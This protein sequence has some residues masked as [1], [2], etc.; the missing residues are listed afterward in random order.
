MSV[1][2]SSALP[3]QGLHYLPHA[4]IEL[5]HGTPPC[6]SPVLPLKR[7]WGRRG[8]YIVGGKVEEE[9]LF[10]CLLLNVLNGFGG[11]HV[12]NIFVFPEGLLAPFM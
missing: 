8:T 7:G 11:E 1:L 12:G 4:P 9:G 5:Y 2:C 3:L 10:L 6:P